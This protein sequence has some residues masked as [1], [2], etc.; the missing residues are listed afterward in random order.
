[1]NQEIKAKW[2]AALRSGEYRQ[3]QDQLRSFNDEFCCLGVL[4][5]LASKAGV[6][7][8]ED[9][10]HDRAFDGAKGNISESVSK[11]SGLKRSFCTTTRLVNM[12]DDEG[13]NFIEIADYIEKVL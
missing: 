7:Q 11:W 12:N 1:M 6:G 2:V 5:D 9:V 4:C 8:W 10:S 3:G 13:F